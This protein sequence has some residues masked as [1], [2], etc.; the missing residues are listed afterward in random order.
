MT[1]LFDDEEYIV[2]QKK[3]FSTLSFTLLPF[4]T[5]LG[6][7]F[8]TG[9]IKDKKI[10]SFVSNGYWYKTQLKD[11][12]AQKNFNKFFWT[13]AT[14]LLFGWDKNTYPISEFKKEVESFFR[15]E[16]IFI[17][18]NPNQKLTLENT[19][20]LGVVS[21]IVTIGAEILFF[22]LKNP[23]ILAKKLSSKDT[24]LA[25]DCRYIM[26][27]IFN[28]WHERFWY[29]K[30]SEQV[31]KIFPDEDHKVVYNFLGITSQNAT[32]EDNTAKCLKALK[33]LK[34][35]K[36]YSVR[37]KLKKSQPVVQST[38]SGGFLHAQ[39]QYLNQIAD[40][41]EAISDGN[42]HTASAQ[43]LRHFIKAMMGEKNAFAL[44][45]WIHL[46]FKG[47]ATDKVKRKE[48]RTP[49]PA[50]YKQIYLYT[51]M[52]SKITMIPPREFQAIVWVGIRSQRS[53]RQQM[54]YAPIFK[55]L[56]REHL[57]S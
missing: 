19:G 13:P 48:L 28:G 54:H 16:I 4:A 29:Q 51:R 25:I 49:S 8:L 42:L 56:M 5:L 53:K 9:E 34:E 50:F 41:G 37:L 47:I 40:G 43:K 17:K 2:Q 1:K 20:S 35:K 52:L 39:I 38:F 57:F 18:N 22:L 30:T 55:S 44:D 7:L 21:A 27:Y 3:L 11:F 46:A 32:I 6:K 14:M 31:K 36:K 10:I 23:G 24:A 26:R 12:S 33:Q 15:K 45:F